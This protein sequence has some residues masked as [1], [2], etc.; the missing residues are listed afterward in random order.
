MTGK[1]E[2]KK[3]PLFPF[4][5]NTRNH[6]KL[7]KA[8]PLPAMHG[9]QLNDDLL[10]SH[11][12]TNGRTLYNNSNG[13]NDGKKHSAHS[14]EGWYVP[15]DG[16]LGKTPDDPTTTLDKS[17]SNNN[18][19]NN[20]NNNDNNDNNSNSNNNKNN[21]KGNNTAN[22]NA[23]HNSH[24]NKNSD[25]V[26]TTA[27][28]G[29]DNGKEK[30]D[31]YRQKLEQHHLYSLLVSDGSFLRPKAQANQVKQTSKKKYQEL[32]HKYFTTFRIFFFF[33]LEI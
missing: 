29:K 11:S 7:T 12:G 18:N 2:N 26:R 23:S 5:A 25:D 6:P 33:F 9:D 20:N 10:L 27:S 32:Q 22:K 28:A 21:T 14:S 13:M 30:L 8:M 24:S 1:E 3:H 16:Y 4:N 15:L 31:I 19:N 17:N